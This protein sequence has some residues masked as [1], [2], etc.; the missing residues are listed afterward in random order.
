MLRSLHQQRP[1]IRIAFF[2]DVQLRLTL[3]RVSSSRLQP[4][5][6]AHVAALAETVRIFQREQEGQRDQRAD[7]LD[8]LQQRHLRITLLGFLLEETTMWHPWKVRQQCKRALAALQEALET[9]KKSI[10]TAQRSM[11]M[12]DQLLAENDQLRTDNEALRQ[13]FTITLRVQ[14]W[15][16]LRRTYSK[17]RIRSRLTTGWSMSEMAIFQ[18]LLFSNGFF[19]FDLYGTSQGG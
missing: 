15:R 18:Q 1:Q 10:E 19:F 8:L 9:T 12:V 16:R 13:E 17:K 7:A 3:T 14:R 6:T 5:I 2:A 4:Q 11:A